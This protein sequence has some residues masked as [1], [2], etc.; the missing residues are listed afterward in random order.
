M[1]SSGTAKDAMGLC[2]GRNAVVVDGFCRRAK[3]ESSQ[4]ESDFDGSFVSSG[5]KATFTQAQT[6]IAQSSPFE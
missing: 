3:M 1:F 6:G 4:C 5:V 2:I